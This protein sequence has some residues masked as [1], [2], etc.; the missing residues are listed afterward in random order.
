MEIDRI[1]KEKLKFHNVNSDYP[2]NSNIDVPN[3]NLQMFKVRFNVETQLRRIWENRFQNGEFE[4]K[5][6]HQPLTRVIEDLTRFEIMD[7]NFYGILREILSICNYAIHG[8][9][10]T[11]KQATFV[12]NNA[13]QILDYLRQTK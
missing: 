3:N 2:T 4:G 6:K 13:N 10:V 5:N 9:N 11:D 12:I 8:E 1:L 7:R